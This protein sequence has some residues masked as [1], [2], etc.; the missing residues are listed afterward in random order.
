MINHFHERLRELDYIL[1]FAMAY[2]VHF[3]VIINKSEYV[4]LINTPIS[5]IYTNTNKE[6]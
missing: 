5:V 4:Q 1:I 2:K 6:R 3:L